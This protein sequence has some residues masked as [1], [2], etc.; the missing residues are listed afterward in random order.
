MPASS[1]AATCHGVTAHLDHIASLGANLLYLTPLF[2]AP[3]NHRYNA[4][5]FEHID[6]LLGGDVAYQAL[7][8][9]VHR[10]G[11]RIIGDL[12]TNHTGSD[13]EWFR[14]ATSDPIGAN[15]PVLLLHRVPAGLGGLD[16]AP[17][18]AEVELQQ[19][20]GAAAHWSPPTTPRCAGTCGP[21]SAWTAGASM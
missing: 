11:M 21:T 20:G 4:S 7:I 18:T 5:T 10:R 12:T 19:P 8:E 17:G 13:H 9:E 1:T 16:G 3:S 15:R 6:P 2:P 14:A